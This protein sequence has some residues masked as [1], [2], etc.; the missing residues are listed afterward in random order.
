MENQ[1]FQAAM[2]QISERSDIN[3][4]DL[5]MVI[6]ENEP[7]DVCIYKDPGEFC[8]A[9]ATRQINENG[10][11]IFGKVQFAKSLMRNC[12]VG[13]VEDPQVPAAVLIF[14]GNLCTLHVYLPN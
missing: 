4:H 1:K 12:Y 9:M 13:I 7:T 6:K 3:G 2:Q 11:V 10:I 14:L 8:D 5:L